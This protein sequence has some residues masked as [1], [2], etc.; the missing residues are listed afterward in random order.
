MLF[1]IRDPKNTICYKYTS[2]QF[3][4]K[5]ELL[6]ATSLQWSAK[7]NKN[8]LIISLGSRGAIY[9][10]LSTGTTPERMDQPSVQILIKTSDLLASYRSS[11]SKIYREKLLGVLSIDVLTI[12]FLSIK[13]KK[14]NI[15]NIWDSDSYEK[16]G[17]TVVNSRAYNLITPTIKM[18]SG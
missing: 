3:Y 18:D 17:Q 4:F 2:Y 5:Q 10:P 7:L 6:Q 12:F 14:S 11:K 1:E 13:C 8:K 16:A 15:L 9:R